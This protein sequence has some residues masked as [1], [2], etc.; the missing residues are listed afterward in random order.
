MRGAAGLDPLAVEEREREMMGVVDTG[1]EGGQVVSLV[2]RYSTVGY[3]STC[4]DVLT[5]GLSGVY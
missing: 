3:T 1:T 5:L 4:S 2:D